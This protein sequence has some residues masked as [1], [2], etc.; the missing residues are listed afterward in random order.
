M[1]KLNLYHLLP[2]LAVIKKR[3]LTMGKTK[4]KERENMVAFGDLNIGNVS[5]TLVLC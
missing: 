4:H 1:S 5:Q 2:N 3:K